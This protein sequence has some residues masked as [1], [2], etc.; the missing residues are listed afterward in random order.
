MKR[1]AGKADVCIV[2]ALV[3]CAVLVFLFSKNASPARCAEIICEGVAVQTVN[4]QNVKEPYELVLENGLVLQVRQ[5]G[6]CVASSPCPDK[7]CVYCGWLEQAGDTAVC[8]PC[9]TIVKITGTPPDGA[10]DAVVY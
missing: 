10:P 4:L 7:L 3:L 5:G 9:R 2:A 8:L 1:K 6:I